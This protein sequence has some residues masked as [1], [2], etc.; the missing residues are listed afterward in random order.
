MQYTIRNVPDDVDLLLRQ[1]AEVTGRS[2]NTLVVEALRRGIG[3]VVDDAEREEHAGME[4]FASVRGR[5]KGQRWTRRL[6]NRLA[7]LDDASRDVRR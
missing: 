2:L 7:E 5:W 3:A 4:R 1:R 6:E